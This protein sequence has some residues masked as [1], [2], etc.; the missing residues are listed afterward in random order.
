MKK[1]YLSLITLITL[2]VG[3]LSELIICFARFY[4]ELWYTIL[5]MDVLVVGFALLSYWLK[6]YWINL[7]SIV[8]LI[9]GAILLCLYPMYIMYLAF[10]FGGLSLVELIV[11]YIISLVEKKT[12]K[13]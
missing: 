6:H 1:K 5:I 11:Y 7:I 8:V 2:L 13:S 3:S 4:G 12:G 9:L 10:I